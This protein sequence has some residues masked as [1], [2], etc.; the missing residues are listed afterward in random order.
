MKDRWNPNFFWT[1]ISN[2]WIKED[3]KYILDD[4]GQNMYTI[5]SGDTGVFINHIFDIPSGATIISFN[6]LNLINLEKTWGWGYDSSGLLGNGSTETKSS[7]VEVSGSHTFCKIYYNDNYLYTNSIFATDI[8]NK[9]WGWGSNFFGQLG[10]NTEIDQY[11]PVEI[12]GD[13]TFSNIMNASS[14][15]LAFDNNNQLWGWGPNNYGQI[16]NGTTE[17]KS[18]P[19]AIYGNHTFCQVYNA[20]L[21]IVAIDNNNETWSWGYNFYG[22]LG[23]GTGENKS[24]PVL[25]YGNHEFYK[26]YDNYVTMFAIDY[27]NKTWGWGLNNYGQLGIG[28]SINQLTPVE[29]QGNHTFFKIFNN[30]NL[31]IP[32]PLWINGMVFAIDNAGQAWSWGNN[33]HGQLGITNTENQSTPVAVYG[34]HTFCDI[35]IENGNTIVAI[36]NNNKAW[37]WGYNYYSELGIGN[38][39][40]QCTPVAI[41]GNHTFMKIYKNRMLIDN[42]G[43]AW[44]WGSNNDYGQLGIGNI[45]D[46][47]SP[48]AIHGNH[49][50]CEIYLND[51]NTIGVDNNNII[52]NWGDLYNG[53][54]GPSG[55]VTTPV[56]I[57]FPS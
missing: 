36:D 33:D 44:G 23:D 41:H 3:L 5:I 38:V 40:N 19:V 48:V 12:Y 32:G 24:T 9:S 46:Q 7:L 43:R 55:Y 25:V 1:N 8:N 39:N 11:T 53:E 52:W 42:N 56:K 54:A 51:H 4:D 17:N 30:V 45:E 26:I 2:K 14:T 47:C 27:D 10:D 15:G 35:I 18:T 6:T 29:I 57:I 22:T 49:T 37:G 13:H 28:N 50:F 20:S 16:G 34:A 31:V 21:S